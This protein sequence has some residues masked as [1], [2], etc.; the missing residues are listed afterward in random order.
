MKLVDIL[1]RITN[2]E[3]RLAS[4]ISTFTTANA[5]QDQPTT[6]AFHSTTQSI[7]HNAA[8]VV[9][10]DSNRYDSASLHLL[11]GDQT[12]FTAPTA[13][14]YAMTLHARFAARTD[15]TRTLFFFRVNGA[16]TIAIVDDDNPGTQST[17]KRLHLATQWK[18]AA[19]DYVQVLAQHVNGGSAAVNINNI[20]AESPEFTMTRVANG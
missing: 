7:P 11:A 1:A 2:L 14:V 17:D 6:R 4:A 9:T 13:G 5:T 15:F 18:M 20:V 8:T 16:T 10:F 19:A 12:K 3:T